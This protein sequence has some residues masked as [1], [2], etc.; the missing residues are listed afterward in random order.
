MQLRLTRQ[1]FDQPARSEAERQA[2]S[3]SRAGLVEDLQRALGSGRLWTAMTHQDQVVGFAMADVVDEMAYLAELAVVPNFG[4]QGIG[5]RLVES[6]IAW[7]RAS[8]FDTLQ[9][10][11]FAHI[12]WNAPFYEKLGFS[13]V[14]PPEAGTEMAGIM[15]EERRAG[16]NKSC[17]VL[18][19]KTL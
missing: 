2:V 14:D 5:K 13:V 18:M 1:R 10:V 6:A 12:P 7:A 9:L 16:I 4:R 15:E 11:T 3:L 8:G 17:R 19:R